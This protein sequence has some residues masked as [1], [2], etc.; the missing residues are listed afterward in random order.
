MQNDEP[1]RKF[2][3]IDESEERAKNLPKTAEEKEKEARD[4]TVKPE[5]K[6]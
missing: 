1:M 4:T 5:K 2:G 3:N 6:G